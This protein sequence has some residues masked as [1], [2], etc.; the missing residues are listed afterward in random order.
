MLT[1]GWEYC[2]FSP[3]RLEKQV[4][5][6]RIQETIASVVGNNQ[7]HQ[8]NY[9]GKTCKIRQFPSNLAGSQNKTQDNLQT[10]INT[11]HP[12]KLNSQCLAVNKILPSMQRGRKIGHIRRIIE[13]STNP[14]LTQILELLNKDISKIIVNV[15]HMLKSQQRYGKQKKKGLIYRTST[16]GKIQQMHFSLF[17]LLSTIKNP[18]NDIFKIFLKYVFY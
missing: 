10:C 15:F 1:Q 2:L 16:S 7:I 11:Q 14:K 6:Q 3:A 18:G 9:I 4:I 5:E 13:Q 8:K 12:T 17:L